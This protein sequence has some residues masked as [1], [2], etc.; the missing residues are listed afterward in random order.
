MGQDNQSAGAGQR[1]FNNCLFTEVEGV[2]GALQSGEDFGA[3]LAAA[4][5]AELPRQVEDMLKKGILKK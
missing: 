4:A 2:R 5:L 1:K 3:A